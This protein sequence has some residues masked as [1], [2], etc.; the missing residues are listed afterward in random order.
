MSEHKRH[1]HHHEHN[2]GREQGLTSHSHGEACA[3]AHEECHG[4]ACACAHEKRCGGACAGEH[5]CEE[6]GCACGHDHSHGGESLSRELIVIGLG[7]ALLIA[8]LLTSG[9]VKTALL[10]LSYLIVGGEILWQALTGLFRGRFVDENVLMSVA[11]IGAMILGD[12]AEGVMVMLLYRVGELLQGIAVRRSR[13]SISAALDLRPDTVRLFIDETET[14]VPAEQAAVGDRFVVLPGERV[15]LDG[16]VLE[17]SSFLDC[18]AI[19]GESVPVHAKEGTRVLS[20]SINQSGRL[21][22]QAEK[23]AGESTAARIMQAVED[24]V[25]TKPRME[26]FITRFAR[27][28]TPVVMLLTLLVAVLPPLLGAGPWKEWIHRGL[29]LLVISCP[30]AL[31]LSV[32]LTFFAG[33]AR[34]SADGVLL[35]GSNVMEALVGVK[36]VALDKTG[37][38]TRGSF[39]VTRV[40]AAPG[41]EEQELLDLAAAV[42]RG[43]IHPIAHAIASAAQRQLVCEGME[44]LAGHGVSG[45]VR[46]R[47]VLAGNGKLLEKEGI[48][49]TGLATAKTAVLMAVDGVYAGRILIDDEIKPGSAGAVKALKGRGLFAALLTGDSPAAAE[50]VAKATGIDEVHAA[51]LP[52]DKL[53]ILRKLRAKHGPTVFVGDG[54]ND[55]P[56]LAG[57]D[58]GC[59]MGMGGSDAA[60]E[61]ADMVLM[62]D[63]LNGLPGAMRVA[64]RTLA[65][66]KANVAFALAVK[67]AVMILG[68]M[69]LAQMWMA[70]FADVGTALLCVLNAL[71]LLPRK[72]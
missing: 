72:K 56:V 51:L 44:E 27:V 34:Q 53:D 71:R 28:Y 14:V 66:A 42:E 25:E 26:N 35:K 13:A 68:V 37:T 59:A 57:A 45:I 70:V 32:P 36:A 18:S 4:G 61:A 20:G 38:I 43:S 11:T 55:S 8:G 52:G 48:A 40:E 12:Y 1:Q 7:I 33:L 65:I 58:V 10:L 69:G 16:I 49:H 23:A 6:S 50:A 17:G 5:G 2:H 30:C 29:L 54:I 15:P 24:A 63:D 3:C 60:V 21:V 46:G 64:E 31:V 9:W 67:L 39:S 41:F 19:T 62:R 22:I 47:R